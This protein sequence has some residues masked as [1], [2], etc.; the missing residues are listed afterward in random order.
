MSSAEFRRSFV[1]A[2][3]N[4]FTS[5]AVEQRARLLRRYRRGPDMEAAVLLAVSTLAPRTLLEVGGGAG[6]LA[7]MIGQHVGARTLAVDRNAALVADARARGVDAVV[8][9]VRALPFDDAT[10]ACVVADRTLRRRRDV[11]HGL[12]EIHRVL[13]AGGALVVVVRSNTCDGHELDALT[14]FKP[15]ARSDALNADNGRRVLSHYFSRI[16]QQTLDYTLEFPTG[17]AAAGYVATLPGRAAQVSR[18]ADVD[19]PIRLTY[20]VRLLVAEHPRTI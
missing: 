14:G 7:S 5:L 2:A 1:L 11:D 16:D 8:A 12:P 20:G 18:I 3:D 17:Q 9:D 4:H 15:H 19:R 6:A 13:D 10:L